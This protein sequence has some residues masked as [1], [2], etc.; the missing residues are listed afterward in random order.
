MNNQD[1]D[2]TE[3]L[4]WQGAVEAQDEVDNDCNGQIDEGVSSSWYLDY[5]GDGYGD[6][7][8][9]E[10]ACTAPSIGQ[11][12]DVG[13]DCDD[14]DDSF[15]PGVAEGC[16]NLD[17]NC[18][19]LID[20]DLDGDLYSDAARGGSDCDDPDLG[21]F[22]RAKWGLRCGRDLLEHLGHSTGQW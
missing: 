19:G 15:S 20:N 3:E 5:D 9:L 17:R 7:L 12:T 18:D 21:R 8:S 11:A 16:D 4:A 13:G 1:C 14:T 2:D 22:T 6:D 10:L